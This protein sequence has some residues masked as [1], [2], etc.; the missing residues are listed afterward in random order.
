MMGCRACGL[1]RSKYSNL[2]SSIPNVFVF[3][4][5]FYLLHYSLLSLTPFTSERVSNG[6]SAYIR[7]KFQLNYFS[8]D[9]RI[10]EIRSVL[11]KI[12]T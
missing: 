7:T 12:D 6:Y 3:D 4:W 11:S 1:N 9:H 8:S 10:F 2:S 5:I